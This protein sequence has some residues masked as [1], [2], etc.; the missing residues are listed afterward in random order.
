METFT[1]KEISD[2]MFNYR[3]EFTTICGKI[4][5][6]IVKICFKRTIST[7]V[8]DEKMYSHYD[9]IYA[10]LADNFQ[11]CVKVI[12]FELKKDRGCYG[13]KLIYVDNHNNIKRCWMYETLNEHE[14]YYSLTR[15]I[16]YYN[17]NVW[18]QE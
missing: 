18:K 8:F 9:K 14:L 5:N 7:L 13:I 15:V 16:D 12:G 2:K 4:K 17:D 6:D 3:F 1:K 11:T 10:M